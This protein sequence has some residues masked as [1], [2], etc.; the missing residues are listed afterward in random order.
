MLFIPIPFIQKDHIIVI[1]GYAGYIALQE[2]VE[3]SEFLIVIKTKVIIPASKKKNKY[4][5]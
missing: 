1:I 3:C 4:I 5:S 2:C